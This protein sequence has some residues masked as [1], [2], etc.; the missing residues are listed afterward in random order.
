VIAPAEDRGLA[1]GELLDGKWLVERVIGQGG[2]GTV[3]QARDVALDRAV[4][5]KVLSPSLASDAELVTRFEREAR[6]TAKLEHPNIVPIYAV[7]RH[8]GTPF[9]VMKLLEGESLERRLRRETSLDLGSAMRIVRP[10]CAG[11]RHIHERGCVHRDLKP[12]NVFVGPDGHV[13]ILDFGVLR[14]TGARGLTQVGALLGTPAYMAPEQVHGAEGADQRA[15]VY[16]LGIIL[17]QL[18]CGRLPFDTDNE[19][20]LMEM[21]RLTPPPRPS[22]LAHLPIE[23]DAVVAR[24]LAKRPADRTPTAEAFLEDLEKVFAIWN[25]DGRNAAATLT[26][27]DLPRRMADEVATPPAAPPFAR[28]GSTEKVPAVRPPSSRPERLVDRTTEVESD[29]P[30]V[31]T[32]EESTHLLEDGAPA[33]LG[34]VPWIVGAVLAAVGLGAVAYFLVR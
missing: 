26:D 12:G 11:L 19:T 3:Y 20:A 22:T 21:Q 28:P 24:A 7:A 9:I 25:R 15:D 2:M 32:G 16:S 17:F 1:K 10:L 33:G 13:T 23:L 14:D 6:V 31:P 27:A 29:L 5:V 4:A 30:R 8:Q 18:L 34:V